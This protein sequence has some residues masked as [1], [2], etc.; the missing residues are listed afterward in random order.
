MAELISVRDLEVRLFDRLGVVVAV[1]DVS[2]SVEEGEVVALVGESGC[3]KSVTALALLRLLPPDAHISG[4]VTF[5]GRDLLRLPLKELRAIRGRDIAMVFQEP[6]TS[7]NP[8]FTIGNQIGEVLRL[9]QGLRGR[10]ARDRA[11]Q[12]LSLVRIGSPEQR[13][14]SYPHQLSGGMRQRAMIAMALACDPK[15]LILDEPTTALD[16]TTQA[17]ILD[18]VRDLR[19]RLGMSI[20]LITHDLGVVAD[21]ADRVAVMYAGS[22]VEDALVHRLFAQ[23]R[24]PYTAGLLRAL[25]R[26]GRRA[27]EAQERLTEIPGLVPVLRELPSACAFAPRCPRSQDDCSRQHPSLGVCE[28]DH[29]VACFHP[30]PPAPAGASA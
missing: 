5:Q 11:A 17:Q 18:I 27:G 28:P 13:L 25:P 22:K 23:P 26:R 29:L 7:L 2:L 3:G 8:S 15:L 9:H 21:L 19:E 10:A 16:V 24:H 14:R 12:L 30:E 1:R 20:L 6:M 4:S